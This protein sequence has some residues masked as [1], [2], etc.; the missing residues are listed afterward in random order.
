M[1]TFVWGIDFYI[2]LNLNDDN[3]YN[4]TIWHQ[5]KLN[6]H[7]TC[8]GQQQQSNHSFYNLKWQFIRLNRR[9]S[10]TYRIWFIL[11]RRSFVQLGIPRK[12]RGGIAIVPNLC[13]WGV[14]RS[15]LCLN[16]S[17]MQ[18]GAWN[19]FEP[20]WRRRLTMAL[21]HELWSFTKIYYTTH[22]STRRAADAQ[23]D[24]VYEWM[25]NFIFSESWFF[26]E[27]TLRVG[28]ILYEFCSH[29]YLHGYNI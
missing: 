15:C 26:W 22:R 2:A 11:Q 5:L 18:R 19:W 13:H 24:V 9:V 12:S 4:I 27:N 3:S 1:G 20:N 17:F 14:F 28:T 6:G 23:V 10:P 29:S 7:I 16:L 8:W 25:Y 21:I